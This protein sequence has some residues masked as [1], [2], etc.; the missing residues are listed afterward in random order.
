MREKGTGEGDGVVF[1]ENWD[2]GEGDG[3]VFVRFERIQYN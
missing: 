2:G 1:G 3:V